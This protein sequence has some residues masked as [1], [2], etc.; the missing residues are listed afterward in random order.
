VYPFAPAYFHKLSSLIRVH[1]SLWPVSLKGLLHLT[2][3]P[4]DDSA[5]VPFVRPGLTADDFT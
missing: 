1:P 5:S 4:L 3:A 2:G